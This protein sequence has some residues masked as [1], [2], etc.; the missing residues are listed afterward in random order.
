MK[1][2]F[3]KQQLINVTTV[4][5]NGLGVVVAEGYRVVSQADIPASERLSPDC[6]GCSP[7]MRSLRRST[8]D[9]LRQSIVVSWRRDVQRALPAI[10]TGA[11][12]I[13]A[14]VGRRSRDLAPAVESRLPARAWAAFVLNHALCG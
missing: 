12:T 5:Q 9:R 10:D 6:S 14:A 8:P 7:S 4:N 1:T 13:T 2:Q 3:G 11:A